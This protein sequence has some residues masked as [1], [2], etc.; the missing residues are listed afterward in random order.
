MQI[1]I[2][3]AGSAATIVLNGRLDIS[4]AD[5]VALPLATLSGSKDKL[6]IDMTDVTFV[7]SIGLRHLVAA[8]KAIS[9]RGGTMIVANP[10]PTV[11]EIITTSGLSD[12]LNV[13]T[14]GAA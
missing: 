11:L 14:G 6:T 3:D 12:I 8:A 1:A 9:R 13:Q 10:T 4:G 2:D 7:A 5:V